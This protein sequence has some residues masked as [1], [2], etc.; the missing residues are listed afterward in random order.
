MAECIIKRNIEIS[1]FL[2]A[3]E[4]TY[5]TDFF[6][7]GESHDFWEIVYVMGGRAGA[8][9]DERVYELSAGDMI[10]HKPTEFHRI[11]SAGGTRPHLFIMSFRLSG[12]AAELENLVIRLSYEQKNAFSELINAFRN[13]TGLVL[14]SDG[15]IPNNYLDGWE[16]NPNEA[17]IIA[18]LAENFLLTVLSDKADIKEVEKNKGAVLY[19][20]IV[21][22]LEDNIYSDISIAEVAEICGM[23]VSGI[24]KSFRRY[25]GESIHRYF[26]RL[27]INRAAQLL[28]SNMSVG[29]ISEVLSF[30]NQNYFS[31]VFKRETGCSPLAYRKGEQQEDR[32]AAI[33]PNGKLPLAAHDDGT[34]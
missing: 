9:A 30:N 12:K 6:F 5:E 3:F 18:N 28:R 10:F 32:S 17:Q 21:G 20:K 22:I 4:P 33:P 2:S 34:K 24:K 11:W 1:S 29:E 16:K 31:T 8:S 15:E 25:S 7:R 27:K 19:K 14:R 23:S 13:R 26:L